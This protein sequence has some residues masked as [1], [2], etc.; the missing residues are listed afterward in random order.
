MAFDDWP[1]T[2][3]PT[4]A[5]VGA[6]TSRTPYPVEQS[7][8]TTRSSRKRSTRVGEQLRRA[9]ALYYV[10]TGAWPLLDRG[11]FERVTG[12]KTEFWLVRTVGAITSVIGASLLAASR[13]QVEPP[14]RILGAG[15]P[16]AFASID[17]VFVAK[18][19]ISPVYALDAV[20]QL[21]L[22]AGWLAPIEDRGGVLEHGSDGDGAG[23]ASSQFGSNG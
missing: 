13:A 2:G 22:A 21:V 7:V 4:V 14:M 16:L 3:T 10:G 18:R 19:R 5:R 6:T 11:S 12:P 17:L 8:P 15:C 9:Q 1:N 20:V 23:D